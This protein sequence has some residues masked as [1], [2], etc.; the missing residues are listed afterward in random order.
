MGGDFADLGPDVIECAERLVGR[1]E[2]L[3]GRYATGTKWGET[4]T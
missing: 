1:G 4:P 3:H 2:V